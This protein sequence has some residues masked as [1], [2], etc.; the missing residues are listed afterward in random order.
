MVTVAKEKP[1]HSAPVATAILNN[2][3]S[4]TGRDVTPVYLIKYAQGVIIVPPAVMAAEF[5]RLFATYPALNNEHSPY[6]SWRWQRDYEDFMQQFGGFLRRH[7]VGLVE[8]PPTKNPF[9]DDE[10]ARLHAVGSE[11]GKAEYWL[12]DERIGQV[13][14][15]PKDEGGQSRA[16]QPD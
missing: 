9:N 7:K 1:N 12:A 2:P 3:K 4:V 11:L 14:V 5:N 10:I 8:N 13:L 16:R 6:R 15:I